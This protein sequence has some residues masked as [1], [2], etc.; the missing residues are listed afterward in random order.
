MIATAA[1]QTLWIT[2]AYFVAQ[3]LC[4]G[5]ACS[6]DGR[7][8]CP[9]PCAE[10]QVTSHAQFARALGLSCALEAGVRIFEWN[11]PMLQDLGGGLPLGACRLL[12]HEY[13]ELDG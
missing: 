13:R 11:G 1:R 4:P 9:P 5:A 6:V 10:L 3:P 7:C 8:R 2:D 12:E